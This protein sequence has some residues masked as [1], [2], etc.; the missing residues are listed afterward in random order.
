MKTIEISSCGACPYFRVNDGFPRSAH[1]PTQCIH[2]NK[3]PAVKEEP[4]AI[5]AP[6]DWCP[7]R[8]CPEALQIEGGP[9]AEP[10]ET[11]FDAFGP[12]DQ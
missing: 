7:L 4:G 11:M 9:K 12:D 1:W 5:T 6:P 3:P 8:L 10:I 2:P